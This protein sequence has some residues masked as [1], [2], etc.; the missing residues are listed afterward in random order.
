MDLSSQATSNSIVAG[1]TGISQAN[2]LARPTDT[3]NTLTRDLGKVGNEIHGT[4]QS[5]D[6][7]NR[8]LALARARGAMRPEPP[9]QFQRFVQEATGKLLPIFGSQ[10]F[11]APQSYVPDSNQAIPANYVL[12]PGDEIRLQ[13]WGAVD[14]SA[15]LLI[16]RN[17]Q[18][19]V[20]KVGVVPLVGVTLQELES[21]LRGHLSKVFT[22]FKLNA[23]LGRLRGIQVYVVGQARQ[24]GTYVV[25]SLSTL[26]NALFL[27][28]GPSASG[29]MRQIQLQ[30]NGKTITRLD[31]Y[32]FIARGDKSQDAALL[33]GDVIFIPPAGPRVAVA[34]AYD[35]AAIYELKDA[36]TTVGSLLRL[37]GG[38]PSTANARKALLER[39]NPEKNPPRQVLDLAL[40]SAGLQQT[41]RDGDVITLL[42]LSPA[43]ANAVTLQGVVAESVRY[44]WFEGMKILDLIPN[45][46]A[47][48]T[49][50]YF[51][52]TNQ[53]VQNEQALKDQPSAKDGKYRDPLSRDAT[54]RDS[55]ARDPLSR[56]PL[57]KDATSKDAGSRLTDRL[58]GMVDQINW[59]YAV[60][61]RLDRDKLATVLVPFNLGK[62]VLQRDPAHNLTL[63]AGDVVTILSQNDLR[64]P[65]D[66]QNRMVRVEG[67]V[68]A[69][70]V[71]QAA[72]GETLPQLIKRIGGLTPQAYVFG[73]EFNRESVR[74]R[75]QENLD[76]LI[77]RLESQAQSQAI[78]TTTNLGADR[79]SQSQALLLQQQAQLKSQID[80]LKTLKSNGRVSM[81]LSSD[82]PA[83]PALALEDGDRILIP[84]M[85]GFVSAFGSVNNENVFIYKPNKTVG[86]VL[87]SA[88]LTEDAEPDQAFVLRADGSIVARRDS[89]GLFSFGTGFESLRVLPGDTVVVPA[90][91]DRESSYNFTV[92][93]LRDWTQILSNFGLGAAAIKTLR[94]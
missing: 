75:Q 7:L 32:D 3:L 23:N 79:A 30:R 45:R 17:G 20:P 48:I 33:P 73:T 41:L 44:R 35:Q 6:E 2:S 16:D 69:P 76:T 13:V 27:S 58:R 15:T 68:A 37:A 25:S 12:G 52:R 53:L 39:V 4:S 26:V 46:E 84:P 47:L 29:S 71:Y 65:Q 50:D 91:I 14:F 64:L 43:F 87:K 10:L 66:R 74:Q 55:L 28:G 18:I 90:Q 88:G 92:R 85:P 61:E 77:R 67:E 36:S 83:L 22:N 40:D 70:G 60:I 72:P 57:A 81:E 5:A 89:G 9:S 62:A 49:P 94:N 31:L 38:A 24:P 78:S 82:A 59:D 11:E 1:P 86:D 8:A 19:L 42:P 34:G 56:D 51:K 80:R 54:S 21:V 93:A 63:L